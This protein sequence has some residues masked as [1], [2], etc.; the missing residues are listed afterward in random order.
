[1]H[2]CVKFDS[3]AQLPFATCIHNRHTQKH[4][5][6]PSPIVGFI[7]VRASSTP[8][9]DRQLSIRVWATSR[10]RDHVSDEYGSLVPLLQA[11]L[12]WDTFEQ[13]SMWQLLCA[14]LSRRGSELVTDH[15]LLPVMSLVDPKQHQEALTGLLGSVVAPQINIAALVFGGGALTLAVPRPLE[16]APVRCV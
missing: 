1:M 16:A 9:T 5:S 10:Y 12:G 15:V 2:T 6:N 11:S 3:L 14:E 4:P 7:N 8:Q 13:T